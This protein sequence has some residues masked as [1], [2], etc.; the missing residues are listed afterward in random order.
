MRAS[1]P[2]RHLKSLR[3][4]LLRW[5]AWRAAPGA[6]LAGNHNPLHAEVVEGAID[7]GFAVAP[8]RR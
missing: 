5:V 4:E 6:A 8:G 7:G 2:V 3:N 1:L